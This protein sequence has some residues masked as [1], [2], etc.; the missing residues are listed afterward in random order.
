[1]YLNQGR[2]VVCLVPSRCPAR[3]WPGVYGQLVVSGTAN[4]MVLPPEAALPSF[5]FSIL[6]IEKFK[7]G[8]LLQAENPCKAM[9]CHPK[10]N[11]ELSRLVYCGKVPFRLPRSS[12]KNFI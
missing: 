4:A 11:K 5:L 3:V 2:F 12:R 8:L 7:R 10:S 6:S 9:E 1:M